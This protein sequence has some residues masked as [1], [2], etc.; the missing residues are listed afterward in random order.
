MRIN[1]SVSKIKSSFDP[2]V[3][4]PSFWFTLH[5]AAVAYPTVPNDITKTMMR[6]FLFGIPAALP[7]KKCKEDAFAYI[8]GSNLDAAVE[9]RRSLFTFLWEFHNY[10]NVKEGKPPVSLA[11][12]E[13]L[14]GYHRGDRGGP[15]R[16]TYT[17]E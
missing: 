10:V 5:N 17:A 1:V 14:Y 6:S 8:T 7:C 11:D 3:F 16:I 9:S 2:D 13:I 4:G 12:A 15:V